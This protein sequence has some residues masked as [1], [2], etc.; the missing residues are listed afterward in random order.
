MHDHLLSAEA[1]CPNASPS[2]LSGL[3][4]SLCTRF[5]DWFATAADYY[6]AATIYEQLAGLSD[7]ELHR[8]GLSRSSLAWDIS[9]A[10]DRANF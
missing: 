1:A 5:A 9:Q 2:S 7:A 4:S 10:C 8:R 6:A 3:G